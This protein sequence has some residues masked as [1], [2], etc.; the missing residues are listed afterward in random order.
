MEKTTL[1]IVIPCFNEAEVLPLTAPRVS[2]VMQSLSARISERS[3]VLFVDDGSFDS[4]WNKIEELCRRDKLFCGVKLSRNEGHQNALMAGYDFA[5]GHCDC[6]ISVDA[7]LQDDLGIIPEF[8]DKYDEGCEVVYGVRKS[9]KSDSAFKKGTAAA[10]YS[11][12]ASLGANALKNHADYRLLGKAALDALA[13]FPEVNLFIRGMIPLI[14]F[15][16]DIVYYDRCE[17][18]AGKTKYPLRK[19]ISFALDGITSFSVKPIR[20]VMGLG[21]L[22]VLLS[23]LAAVY[24]FISYFNGNTSAGWASIMISVWF[25]GGVLLVSIGIIGEYTGKIY[26]EVKRRPRYIPEKTINFEDFTKET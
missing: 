6:V 10:F 13:E 9:R 8:L 7:D 23:I 16:S 12:M 18:A 21:I 25:I 24:V 22:T 17:R 3:R 1:Y 5:R 11:S 4:T 20:I 14:G 15:K 2:E 26:S 19:M